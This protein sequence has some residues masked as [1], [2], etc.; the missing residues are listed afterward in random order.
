M[1]TPQTGAFSGDGGPAINAS[2]NNPTAIAFDS[3]GVL[4]IADQFNQRI[5]RV[6]LDSTITTI[7]GN[8]SAGYAGDGGSALAASLNFPG[9]ITAD[10]GGNIYF[11]DDENFVTRR[12]STGGIITTV[13]GN[14][15][16]FRRRRPGDS[17]FS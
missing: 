14:G 11:N 3:T 15:R 1:G 8:G 12:V 9:A 10:A 7:A 17:C 16:D 6:T 5:R 2:L 13:A 4:Y